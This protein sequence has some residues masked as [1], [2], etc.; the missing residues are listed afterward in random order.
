[1]DN[2]VYSPVAFYGLRPYAG[3]LVNHSSIDKVTSMG[4]PLLYNP[5]TKGATTYGVPYAGLR[6]EFDKD[7]T[8]EYRATKSPD[9]KMVHGV[10]ATM[11]KEISDDVFLQFTLGSEKGGRGYNNTYGM[12]GLVWK[13]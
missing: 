11:K 1:M 5:P 6:Y 8:I 12:V 10:K 9:F 3:V 13:F 4:S 7:F 2:T